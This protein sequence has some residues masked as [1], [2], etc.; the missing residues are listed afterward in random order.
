MSGGCGTIA[1][2][3]NGGS[4]AMAKSTH[5]QTNSAHEDASSQ[6]PPVSTPEQVAPQQAQPVYQQQ[7]VYYPQ[8]QYAPRPPRQVTQATHPGLELSLALFAAIASAW[9][10]G[11][12]L[13]GT[14]SLLAGVNYGFGVLSSIFVDGLSGFA[15]VMIA[16]AISVVAAGAAF[17]LFGRTR[18]A[19]DS[20]DYKVSLQVG[21]GVAAVKT[22]VLAASTVA[23]G[24]TPLLTLQDGSNVGPVYLAQFLPLLVTTVLFG[25]LS[26]YLLKLVGKQQ[27]G[28]LLST[29][30][31]IASSVVFL[32][33]LIVVIVKSHSS[34]YT[35]RSSTSDSS[36]RS[37]DT[38]SSTS[39]STKK[40]DDCTKA[41]D[42]YMDGDMSASEY[43]KACS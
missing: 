30:L 22:V 29:I 38:P 6:T 11:D 5:K 8:P 34:D 14:L 31:L 36:S 21:F 1:V 25:A 26:W 12:A 23:V 39:P 4:K 37:L 40:Y 35:P 20:G 42:K 10:F 13:T 19:I 33:G 18:T 32:F 3:G 7:P 9:F 28:T 15:G 16:A 17:W 43:R 27:V 41:A 24:L 2:L